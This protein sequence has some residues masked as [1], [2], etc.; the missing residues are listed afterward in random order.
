MPK[1]K[2][3]KGNPGKPKGC[4]NKFTTLKEA[5][6]NTFIRIGGEDRLVELLSPDIIIVKNKKGKILRKIDLASARQL[7]FV[8]VIAHM[9]PADVQL[10]GPGGNPLPT[11]PP[12]VIFIGV[13]GVDNA[14]SNGSKS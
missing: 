9:L 7:D 3:P 4:K 1:Y 8:K 12:A 11:I 14:D 6:I 13:P 5:F 10:S 2:F